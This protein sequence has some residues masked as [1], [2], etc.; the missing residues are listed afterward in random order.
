MHR[1]RFLS[2][3]TWETVSFAF[4][5]FFLLLPFPFSHS[6]LT[7]CSIYISN[8][9]NRFLWFFLAICP[10]HPSLLVISLDCIYCSHRAD[11]CKFCW[12]V[13]TGESIWN[14]HHHHVVPQSRI[15]LTLSRHFSQLF[16]AS[17]RS[18]GLHPSRSCCMYVWAGRPA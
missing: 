18:S 8:R 6:I 13:N 5:V 9:I 15:S 4:T 7:H 17:D 10:Y 11:D 3:T 12:S 2:V 14:H 16:I 1:F